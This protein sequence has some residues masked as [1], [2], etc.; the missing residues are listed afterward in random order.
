M[1]R[2]IRALS[3]GCCVGFESVDTCAR[4]HF[5]LIVVFLQSVDRSTTSLVT[6]ATGKASTDASTVRITTGLLFSIDL[7]VALKRHA[8]GRATCG[9]L[10]ATLYRTNRPVCLIHRPHRDSL[11]SGS[12]FHNS[13]LIRNGQRERCASSFQAFSKKK[14]NRSTNKVS[15]R[16]L[17]FH[18]QNMTKFR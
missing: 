8:S 3:D 10:L 14:K 4:P 6:R 11:P 16:K 1:W 9:H 15:P 13:H 12:A 2:V 7:L 17:V 18:K 5:F